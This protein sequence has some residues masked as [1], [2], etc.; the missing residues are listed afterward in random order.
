MRQLDDASCDPICIAAEAC[1]DRSENVIDKHLEEWRRRA[2]IECRML[3]KEQLEI[4]S[5]E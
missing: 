1:G 2:P 3:V 5:D 4:R